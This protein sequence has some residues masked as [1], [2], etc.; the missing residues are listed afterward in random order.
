MTTNNFVKKKS[1][2]FFTNTFT[3]AGFTGIPNMPMASVKSRTIFEDLLRRVSAGDLR[4]RNRLPGEH[5]LAE[6]YRCSRPTLRKA[7]GDLREAGCTLYAGGNCP[8]AACLHRQYFQFRSQ[9]LC[10]LFG[11]FYAGNDNRARRV[12]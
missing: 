6:W 5:E 12:R 3:N 2:F 10:R 11:A 8:I 4:G 1:V 7:L 9:R